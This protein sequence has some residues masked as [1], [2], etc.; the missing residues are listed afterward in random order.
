MDNEVDGV[1]LVEGVV[2]ED[3]DAVEAVVD[4]D[5]V[6]LLKV[7]VVEEVVDNIDIEVPVRKTMVVTQGGM[8]R[9]SARAMVTKQWEMP[10]RAGRHKK[11]QKYEC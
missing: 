2:V 6:V 3:D 1:E 4:V 5:V 11:P 10:D 9:P 8:C 7:V